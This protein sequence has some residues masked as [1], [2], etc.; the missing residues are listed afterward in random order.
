MSAYSM[1]FPDAVQMKAL[2]HA[3]DK[4][5]AKQQNEKKDT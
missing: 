3:A 5:L 1:Q 2:L 4:L